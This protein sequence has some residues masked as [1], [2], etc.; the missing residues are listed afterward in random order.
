MAGLPY[1]AATTRPRS[2]ASLL[3][4]Q[5]KGVA[6]LFYVAATCA[7]CAGISPSVSWALSGPRT[8]VLLAVAPV[9]TATNAHTQTPQVTWATGNGSPGIV[10]VSTSG[11]KEAF[12]AWGTEGSALAPWLSPAH[13]YVFRLLL[14]RSH[15]PSTS[16]PSGR[17]NYVPSNRRIATSSAGNFSLRESIAGVDLIWVY[18]FS[19]LA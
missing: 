3:F 19:G 9:P 18:R 7:W 4:R 12:F 11:L 16:T 10:T 1:R 5:M 17:Q 15:S 2:G 14:N 8:R 6:I 13:I